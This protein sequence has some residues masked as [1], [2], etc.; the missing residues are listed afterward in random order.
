MQLS[1]R[2]WLFLG[3]IFCVG[4]PEDRVL[5]D[6][7]LTDNN[8]LGLISL[9]K[10]AATY[11]VHDPIYSDCAISACLNGRSAS[12]LCP[13]DWTQQTVCQ[14][15]EG[16]GIEHVSTQFWLQQTAISSRS[17]WIARSATTFPP[18]L[19]LQCPVPQFPQRLQ[20]SCVKQ[21]ASVH[22]TATIKTLWRYKVR[23]HEPSRRSAH[24][25]SSS[26]TTKCNSGTSRTFQPYGRRCATTVT[27]ELWT[28]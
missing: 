17:T 18:A 28:R 2:M 12:K 9:W 13:C 5:A 19:C 7:H 14:K 20:L 26:S 1:Q 15:G 6:S 4:M 23:A 11:Q 22:P 16:I 24:S 8:N 21:L 27:T 3:N 10:V 25:A